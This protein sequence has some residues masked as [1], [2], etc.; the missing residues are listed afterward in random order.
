MVRMINAQFGNTMWVDESRVDEYKSLGH[1]LA[2]IPNK[3]KKI[4]RKK[5]AIKK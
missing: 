3:Q 1:K 2:N 4:T 5:R